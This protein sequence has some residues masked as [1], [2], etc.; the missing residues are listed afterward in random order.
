PSKERFNLGDQLVVGAADARGL[1]EYLIALI[2]KLRGA[3]H[4]VKLAIELVHQQVIQE[5]RLVLE[6]EVLGA[7]GKA[8]RNEP[9]RRGADALV[10]QPV[11]RSV[12]L[13]EKIA[14]VHDFDTWTFDLR[15]V[16]FERA[17]EIEHRL[18]VGAHQRQ[19]LSFQD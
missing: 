2:G 16:E 10:T 4:R 3:P 17:V 12:D 14:G 11:Q 8:P 9:K 5:R 6:V 18:P 15:T 19:R 7:G 1:P 13:A